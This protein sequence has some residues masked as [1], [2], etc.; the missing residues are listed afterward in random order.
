MS[1]EIDKNAYAQSY[2]I[3]NYLLQIGEIIVPERLIN[4]IDSKRNKDYKFDINDINKVEILPDTEKILTEVFLECIATSKEKE[5]INLLVSNLRKL[6][7]N[8]PIEETQKELLPM[9]LA[10]L[11]WTEKFKIAIKKFLMM[12]NPMY[13]SNSKLEKNPGRMV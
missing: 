3:V 4:N 12:S 9:S 1:K 2:I 13:K 7:I 5:Q 6:I 8:E 11:K 10:T